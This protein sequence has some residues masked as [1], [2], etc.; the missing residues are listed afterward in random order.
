LG[1]LYLN[2]ARVQFKLVRD[3]LRFIFVAA[4]H[5]IEQSSSSLLCTVRPPAPQ[6]LS[7]LAAEWCLA[8]IVKK[9]SKKNWKGVR[10]FLG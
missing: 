4:R 6:N 1:S 5:R 10:R 3:A 2:P 8:K 7:S 9:S